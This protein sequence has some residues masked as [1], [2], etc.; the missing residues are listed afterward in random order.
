M[1]GKGDEV[2]VE[3]EEARVGVFCVCVC[4]R[5]SVIRETTGPARRNPTGKVCP[6]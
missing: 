2:R 1:A 6:L 3:R 4:A 5:V